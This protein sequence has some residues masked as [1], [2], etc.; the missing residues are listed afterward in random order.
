M[1]FRVDLYPG[2]KEAICEALFRRRRVTGIQTEKHSFCKS[3]FKS[4]YAIDG[5]QL[6]FIH[7]VAVKN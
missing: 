4:C 7:S 3:F 5:R 6:Y 1:G 2:M